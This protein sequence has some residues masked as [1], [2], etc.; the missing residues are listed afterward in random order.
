[1]VPLVKELVSLSQCQ[2]SSWSQHYEE[3]E[4]Q[5]PVMQEEVLHGTVNSER[6]DLGSGYCYT[7]VN[8]V[9]VHYLTAIND[10]RERVVVYISECPMD[11]S[12]DQHSPLAGLG[13][14]SKL[15]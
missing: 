1:M 6:A 5:D 11:N 14:Q 13:E 4:Q 2:H 8:I 3:Q 10:C 12:T 15:P 9:T 7:N